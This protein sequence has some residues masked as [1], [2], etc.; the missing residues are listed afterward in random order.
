MKRKKV[1]AKK[2][3]TAHKGTAQKK[4][5][6]K[7]GNKTSPRMVHAVLRQADS[8]KLRIEGL[9][10]DEI[11]HRLGYA[12]GSSAHYAV[13]AALNKTLQEPADQLRKLEMIRTDALLKGLWKK[14]LKGTLGAI[15]RVIKVMDHRAKLSG[16]Y[17]NKHE[18]QLPYGIAVKHKFDSSEIVEIGKELAKLGVIGNESEEP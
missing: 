15:D 3:A 7:R 10:F 9:T 2:P 8:L 11:A 1:Q 14:V 17:I 4:K 13:T 5:R 16:L 6:T 12:D 18:V